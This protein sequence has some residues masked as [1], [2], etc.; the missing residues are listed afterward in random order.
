MPAKH[1][2]WK[3]RFDIES[4]TKVRV[5]KPK[6][7]IWPPDSHFESDIA[8]N[9]LKISRLP[10]IK[11]SVVLLKFRVDIQSQTKVKSLEAKKIQYGCQVTILKVTSLKVPMATIYI[12]KKFEIEILKQT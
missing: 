11:K 12:H 1:L 10:P 9:P 7:P 8:E 4:Q 5:W 2:F 3:R 6:N